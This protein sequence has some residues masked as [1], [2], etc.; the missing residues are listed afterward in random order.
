MLTD[1]LRSRPRSRYTRTHQF[2]NDWRLIRKGATTDAREHII[3]ARGAE[4]IYLGQHENLSVVLAEVEQLAADLRR[5]VEAHDTRP[6]NSP[7]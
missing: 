4:R 6:P 7:S 2:A 1:W 5:F 3:V